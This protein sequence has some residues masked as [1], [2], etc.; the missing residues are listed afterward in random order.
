MLGKGALRIL[1]QVG[2]LRWCFEPSNASQSMAKSGYFHADSTD[3]NE[4]E[5]RDMDVYCF[6]R[7]HTIKWI[8]KDHRRSNDLQ[9]LNFFSRRHIRR[10]WGLLSG[11]LFSVISPFPR[12][13]S[14]VLA[15][16]KIFATQYIPFD[17]LFYQNTWAKNYPAK[18]RTREQR[19]QTNGI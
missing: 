17:Q 1:Q 4:Q 15:F 5:S 14:V 3:V 12:G 6:H 16:V 18:W 10:Y 13:S 9:K 2:F 19:K 11:F 8:F 7:R